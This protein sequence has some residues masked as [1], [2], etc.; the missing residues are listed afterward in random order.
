MYN[1]DYIFQSRTTLIR[2]NECIISLA[3]I[4]KLTQDLLGNDGVIVPDTVTNK[5]YVAYTDKLI[6]PVNVIHQ[7]NYRLG[8][9]S[10]VLQ[11]DHADCI[12]LNQ[13]VTGIKLSI[14]NLRDHFRQKYKLL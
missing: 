1:N 6:D 5:I 14:E 3:D 12:D 4:A 8:T 7:L 10:P 9:M 13:F 11:V 2:I